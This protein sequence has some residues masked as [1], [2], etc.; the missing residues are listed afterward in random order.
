MPG[1]IAFR[2]SRPVR[3]YQLKYIFL[4]S[5]PYRSNICFHHDIWSCPPKFPVLC[6]HLLLTLYLDTSKFLSHVVLMYPT[7]WKF[8]RN[9]NNDNIVKFLF[10]FLSIFHTPKKI[11]YYIAVLDRQLLQHM[12]QA[13]HILVSRANQARIGAYQSCYQ[14]S[15]NKMAY[16]V[17]IN[18]QWRQ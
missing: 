12:C 3:P 10:T 15:Q 9:Y 6:F 5:L 16:Y 8:M 13:L 18:R 7:F 2:S 1:T 11:Y 14:R 4:I 17:T